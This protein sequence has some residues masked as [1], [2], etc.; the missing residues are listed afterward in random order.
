MTAFCLEFHPEVELTPWRPA[1]LS[2]DAIPSSAL[3]LWPVDT[4]WFRKLKI[5]QH[6]AVS[7]HTFSLINEVV[8]FV[9][10]LFK[11]Y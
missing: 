9:A 11:V 10:T 4:G 6:K 5:K 7:T 1:G 3:F 2:L 8:A